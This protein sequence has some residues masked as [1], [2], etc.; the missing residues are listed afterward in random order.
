[1]KKCPKDFRNYQNLI[2]LFIHLRDGNIKLKEVLKGQINFKTD[3]GEIK[4]E[5]K[6]SKSKD[7]ISVIQN[8][9]VIFYLREKSINFFREFSFFFYLRLNTK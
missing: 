1:M 3:L 2:E 6:K 7:Q 4:N 5:I 8:V 9:Q